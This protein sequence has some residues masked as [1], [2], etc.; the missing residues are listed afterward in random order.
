MLTESFYIDEI[1]Y[2]FYLVYIVTLYFHAQMLRICENMEKESVFYYY[3]YCMTTNA[4]V[5]NI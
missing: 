3:Y 4:M 2:Y 1:Y 5:T